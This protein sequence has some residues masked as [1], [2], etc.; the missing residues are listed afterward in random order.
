MKLVANQVSRQWWGTLVSPATRNHIW[1]E[2]GM[3]RYAE[4]FYTENVNGAGAMED[5]GPRYL[6]GGPD[7]GAAAVDSIRPAGRLFAG[8]LGRHGRQRRGCAAH[9]ARRSSATITS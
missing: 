2:N 4:L 8:V 5:R 6:R 7:G 1:I 3:A 9:A